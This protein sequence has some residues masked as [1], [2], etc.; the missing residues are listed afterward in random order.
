MCG[1][2]CLFPS[3]G[4]SFITKYILT[5]FPSM[6]YSLRLQICQSQPGFL[7][8]FL[9]ISLATWKYQ[10]KLKD[11]NAGKKVKDICVQV[12]LTKAG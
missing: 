12:G 6:F 7:N 4:L 1:L 3:T 8:R 2:L 10:K 9:Q 5:E 11:I